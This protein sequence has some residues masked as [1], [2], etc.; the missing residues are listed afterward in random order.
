MLAFYLVTFSDMDNLAH[1]SLGVSA[2]NKVG[3]VPG[4]A[5]FCGF[6]GG[7]VWFLVAIFSCGKLTI[8]QFSPAFTLVEC[9]LSGKAST[10][11]D[12]HLLNDIY[13]MD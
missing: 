7:F 10:S 5:W 11:Q 8:E 2:K 9:P 13:S 1:S 4:S 12:L 6:F 3:M